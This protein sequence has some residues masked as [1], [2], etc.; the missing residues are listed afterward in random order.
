MLGLSHGVLDV[1]VRVQS[2]RRVELLVNQLERAS[3]F[4]IMLVFFLEIVEFCSEIL[5]SD[6]MWEKCNKKF[7]ATVNNEFK[8]NKTENTTKESKFC[9]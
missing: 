4:Q 9:V 1:T 7:T 5:Q 8:E 2:N 3:K 6:K